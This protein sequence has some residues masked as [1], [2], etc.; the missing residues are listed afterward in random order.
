[1]AAKR[2]GKVENLWCS[3]CNQFHCRA[4]F[5]QKQIEKKDDTNRVCKVV[6]AGKAEKV[7]ELWCSECNQF[8][9][10]A[11]FSQKQIEKKDDTNRVCKAV[12]SWREATG[13]RK[14]E[15]RICVQCNLV[16]SR[17]EF[18]DYHQLGRCCKLCAEGNDVNKRTEGQRVQ[19]LI[20]KIG[21]RNDGF[22]TNPLSHSV[23]F[24]DNLQRDVRVP[25]SVKGKIGG[26]CKR[27]AKEYL[28]EWKRSKRMS[29][30][31]W[32]S[33][34][35][36]R[37]THAWSLAGMKK[38]RKFRRW[39]AHNVVCGVCLC[40][41]SRNVATRADVVRSKVGN[42]VF[43]AN[44]A[45]PFR[46]GLR[47][48]I[49]KKGGKKKATEEWLKER[50]VCDRC[51]ADM[52]ECGHAA[53][54]WNVLNPE[55]KAYLDAPPEELAS[56]SFSERRLVGIVSVAAELHLARSFEQYGLKGCVVMAPRDQGPLLSLLQETGTR[57]FFCFFVFFSTGNVE[58]VCG[59]RCVREMKKRRTE[60]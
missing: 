11:Q 41:K 10:R 60:K 59:T 47:E 53:L 58:F 20:Q 35:A 44:L 23:D 50:Y 43:D 15:E 48:S 6:A 42:G 52:K 1:M 31:R 40:M 14:K 29:L 5:S 37:M 36:K 2:A 27:N 9:C 46:N 57:V 33:Q 21:K 34:R 22:F 32:K 19:K 17:D 13:T 25:K 8:H 38:S 39:F 4:Q 18:S 16:K 54:G 12:A 56:L 55:G 45:T 51:C 3:E 30:L 28:E 49:G 7:Q 26:F 24:G